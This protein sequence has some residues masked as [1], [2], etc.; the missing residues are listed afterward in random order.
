MRALSLRRNFS[1]SCSQQRA[2]IMSA[3]PRAHCAAPIR[4]MHRLRSPVM[5]RDACH[6][7]F[8]CKA[9]HRPGRASPE[10]GPQ[11]RAAAP[12][13]AFARPPAPHR[14]P[15]WRRP[16]ETVVQK[17]VHYR[18]HQICW[19][20]WLGTLNF[21][22]MGNLVHKHVAASL[23]RD[24]DSETCIMGCRKRICRRRRCLRAYLR[25]DGD[26]RAAL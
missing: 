21:G 14:P 15:P 24:N 16:P 2:P 22:R 6:A 5:L 25:E 20:A 23:R 11:A 7:S 12:P 4:H 8:P 17:R 10:N 3:L 19:L 13:S 18:R 1:V 26:A 9:V